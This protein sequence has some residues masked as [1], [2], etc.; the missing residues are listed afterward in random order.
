MSEPINWVTS[1]LS[2]LYGIE[3]AHMHWDETETYETS[4]R[5]GISQSTSKFNGVGPQVGLNMNY[6]PFA[7]LNPVL[8]GL[9]V[10]TRA[11]GSLLM[12]T[13]TSS[14]ADTYNGTNIGMVNTD[15]TQRVIAALHARGG[16]A[17][18]YGWDRYHVMA[19]GGYEYHSYING[20]Q[21]LGNADDVADGQYTV[22][23]TNFDLSGFYATLKF[24]ADL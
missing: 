17:Y 24:S 5:T 6:R 14:L 8:G 3:Y 10:E 7:R 13:S 9:S 2:F 11:T 1:D 4:A 12:A 15:S 16:L 18:T 20:L 23:Y 19:K 21:R 22:K